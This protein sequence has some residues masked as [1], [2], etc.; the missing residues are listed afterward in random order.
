MRKYN[1]SIC[2]RYIQ[3][4][5][6]VHSADREQ[7]INRYDV[8]PGYDLYTVSAWRNQV[9]A[10]NGGV[11]I[12]IR[13]EASKSLINIKRVTNRIMIANFQSNLVL[14]SIVT[15]APC[16]Y[17]DEVVK[18]T[19]YEKL[20]T[21]I[22]HVPSHILLIILSDMNARMGPED[23]QYTYNTST[24]NNGSRLIEMMEEYQLTHNLEKNEESYGPGCHH[25]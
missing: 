23:V 20:R 4:H 15:Y 22:E 11:G 5:R 16:Q 24:N 7:E 2:G 17:E 13:K 21:T 14:T 6:K 25:I 18:N 12:I 10:A 19:F 1:I 3:E 9:Q 8:D